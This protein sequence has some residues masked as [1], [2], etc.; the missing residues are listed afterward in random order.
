[1]GTSCNLEVTFK[2]EIKTE[3]HTVARL[4]E[5]LCYRHKG[6]VFHSH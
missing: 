4:V 6:R 5:E 3:G 1:M 2:H